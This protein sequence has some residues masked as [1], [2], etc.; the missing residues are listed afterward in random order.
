MKCVELNPVGNFGPWEAS[1]LR[2]LKKK[3]LD[4]SIG[5]K[6]LFENNTIKV[7][8]VVL[9]PGERLP[10]RKISGNYNL[11]SITEGL[12]VSRYANGKISLVRIKEGDSMFMK[13][14]GQE[15]IY[16]FE[17]IG[18]NILFLHAMEFKPLLEKTY[19]LQKGSKM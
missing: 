19:G 6:L 9:F 8:E 11:T 1:K 14:D 2:E 13:H 16:D 10:F 3:K 4:N 15:S 7:W 5:Q 18:E 17:N 12:A